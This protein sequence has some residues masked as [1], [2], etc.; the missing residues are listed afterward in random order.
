MNEID[1]DNRFHNRNVY[2]FELPDNKLYEFLVKFGVID[3]L[4]RKDE[5]EE[6]TTF[7]QVLEDII[8]EEIAFEYNPDLAANDVEDHEEMITDYIATELVMLDYIEPMHLKYF[9][10]LIMQLTSF[11][12]NKL[13][14][15][16]LIVK[17]FKLLDITPTYIAFKIEI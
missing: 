14:E 11:V 17:D 1:T 12:I 8:F 6:Y 10:N 5:F 15:Q 2:V 3:Y 16:D 13:T 4:N 9:S 7:K